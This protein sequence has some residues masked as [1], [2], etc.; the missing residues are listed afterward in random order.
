[1][2]IPPYKGLAIALGIVCVALLGLSGSIFWSY[3]WIKVQVAFASEQ[4]EIFEAMRT[5]ALQS[6][7]SEAAGFLEYAY[8]YYPSGTKQQTGSLLDHIVER[9]RQRAVRDI[10]ASLRIKTGEDLG[11]SPEAWIQ[12]YGKR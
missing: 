10:I 7:S 1:M 12:K 5:R 3:G 9:E 4:T 2:S 11:D 6:G 8:Y